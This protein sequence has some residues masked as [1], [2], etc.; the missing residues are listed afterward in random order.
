MRAPRDLD[1]LLRPQLWDEL[2]ALTRSVTTENVRQALSREQRELPD[3]AALISP[4]ARPFLD[5]MAARSRSLTERRF[6]RNIM[7]Y[8]PLYISNACV[9][10][11]TYCGFAHDHDFKRRTLNEQ[12][13]GVEIQRL[14]D[15]GFAHLLLLTGEDK[16]AVPVADLARAVALA[17]ARVASVSVEVYP[18]QQ[19]DYAQL[20]EAGCDSLTL[21]QETYHQPAYARVHPKGPKANYAKRLAAPLAAAAAGMRSVSIGA[22]LGLADWRVE[23]LYMALHGA[24]LHHLHYRTR[25]SFGFP[26]LR[27]DPGGGVALQPM[28]EADLAQL[29]FAMRL[30]FA[31]ADLV[32]STRER[33]QFRDGMI[34]LGVTRMSAGSKTQPGGYSLDNGAGEQFAITDAR[35]PAE[36]FAVIAARGYE[37]VWKDFDQGFLA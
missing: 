32:I 14:Q 25:L 11:C 12:E 6:G 37:P 28:S 3:L 2:A 8:V 35:S 7:L 30:V 13:I 22:L 36:V 15:E 1:S 17:H 31:D 24:L 20:I 4:L 26:R 19:Q 34:G 16:R 18:M 27:D 21:Y 23:A 33:Q 29:I 10:H 5:E 9:N